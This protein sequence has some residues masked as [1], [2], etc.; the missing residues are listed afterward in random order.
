[1]AKTTGIKLIANNKK[2]FH[3]KDFLDF[4]RK[5]KVL[6]QALQKI[7]DAIPTCS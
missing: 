4:S 5:D 7:P 2:A 6:S 1:M 3:E